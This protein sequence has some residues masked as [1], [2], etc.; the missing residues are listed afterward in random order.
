ML[1]PPAPTLL[2]SICGVLTGKPASKVSVVP[3]DAKPLIRQ[4]SVLV[5]P[6]S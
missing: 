4:T 5:P 1:P 2:M 6:M 3:A